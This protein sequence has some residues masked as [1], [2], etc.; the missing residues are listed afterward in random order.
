[1]IG[2]H[3]PAIGPVFCCISFWYEGHVTESRRSQSK[4]TARNPEIGWWTRIQ[5]KVRTVKLSQSFIRHLAMK[6]HGR[7]KGNIVSSLT[8][9]LDEVEWSTSW[10]VCF[11][12]TP[13]ARRP[14]DS[15]S[16]SRRLSRR[17]CLLYLPG[18]QPRSLCR[19]SYSP[20]NVPARHVVRC[21]KIYRTF[22]KLSV[23]S[24]YRVL[25]IS[26]PVHLYLQ[27]DWRR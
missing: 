23:T 21:W 17:H 11:T 4:L 10:L 19:T 3:V 13:L 26:C 14:V 22:A 5:L 16:Q 18:I 2:T 6:A 8:L 7:V 9:A 25:Y 15:R 27:T 24:V 12:P 20:M 1:M